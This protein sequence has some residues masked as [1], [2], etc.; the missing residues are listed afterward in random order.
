MIWS[1]DDSEI[2][3]KY[4][5]FQFVYFLFNLNVKSQDDIFQSVFYSL[6]YQNNS[7]QRK[8]VKGHLITEIQ[9]NASLE[10]QSVKLFVVQQQ[11]SSNEG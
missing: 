7:K 9:Y 11:H 3:P 5:R 4:Y 8:S 6:L 10:I 1:H 2:E